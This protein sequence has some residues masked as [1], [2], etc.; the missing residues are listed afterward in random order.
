MV[1]KRKEMES[2]LKK[3]ML[4]AEYMQYGPNLEATFDTLF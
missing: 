3:K 4:Y 2:Y 1:L